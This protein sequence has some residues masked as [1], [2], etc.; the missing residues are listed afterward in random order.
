M[1]RRTDREA[2]R[3]AL[4]AV[5]AAERESTSGRVADLSRSLDDIVEAAALEV[6]DD[7]HDPEGHTIGFERAQVAALLEAARAHLAEVDGAAARLEAG[8]YGDCGRC[9][10]PITYERLLA[11]PTAQACVACASARA[12]GQGRVRTRPGSRA[13]EV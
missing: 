9:G 7:E 2:E 10:R 1:T 4:R 11:R 3:E 12:P 6:P 5:L 8:A 13:A